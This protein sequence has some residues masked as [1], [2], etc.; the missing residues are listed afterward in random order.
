MSRANLNNIFP[1]TYFLNLMGQKT[2]NEKAMNEFDGASVVRLQ[3][4]KITLLYD[5][6]IT[7][8]QK[9][10]VRY[11]AVGYN[12]PNST[13]IVAIEFHDA[14]RNSVYLCAINLAGSP[15]NTNL[16]LPIL[17]YR[18]DDTRIPT[19]YF[20]DDAR[21]GHRLTMQTLAK[22][23]WKAA[24]KENLINADGQLTEHALSQEETPFTFRLETQKANDRKTGR[25][26]MNVRFIPLQRALNLIFD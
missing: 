13:P 5:G 24:Q 26:E 22:R 23:V 12:Y 15:D 4:A 19:V 6:Y 8:A 18:F 16:R 2:M 3:I 20:S 14:A 7:D 11:R 10:R 17:P 25:T 1:D 9:S 21:T